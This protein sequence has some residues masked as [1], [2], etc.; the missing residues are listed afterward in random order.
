MILNP[1]AQRRG[2]LEL[3]RVELIGNLPEDVELPVHLQPVA[4]ADAGDPPVIAKSAV[5]A[6]GVE[7]L[8]HRRQGGVL[9]GELLVEPLDHVV[10]EMPL[11]VV[12]QKAFPVEVQRSVQIRR[13]RGYLGPEGHGAAGGVPA[14]ETEIRAHGPDGPQQGPQ[15]RLVVLPVPAEVKVVGVHVI[16]NQLVHAVAVQVHALGIVLHPGQE[17]GPALLV[18]IVI[19]VGEGPGAVVCVVGDAEAVVSQEIAE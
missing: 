15:V 7:P 14:V 9:D 2:V 10:R 4:F 13:V 5:Q 1:L 18:Q 3:R 6:G 12:D 16:G 11:V 19:F 17:D 8:L